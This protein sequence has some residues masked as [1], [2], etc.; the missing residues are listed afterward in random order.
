MKCTIL[1][2]MPLFLSMP[3][4]SE[5]RTTT[6][7]AKPTETT[8]PEKDSA[9]NIE[10]QFVDNQM[11]DISS[12]DE[13]SQLSAGE[14]PWI[15][16]LPR[17]GSNNMSTQGPPGEDSDDASFQ[18]AR[19]RMPSDASP[20]FE[21]EGVS[22]EN[23]S[24]SAGND[25]IPHSQSW[26]DWFFPP[27]NPNIQTTQSSPQFGRNGPADPSRKV[28]QTA[29]SVMGSSHQSA[30][31]Q[32]PMQQS[33]QRDDRPFPPRQ[34]NNSRNDRTQP[35]RRQ[36]AGRQS[37]VRY[38]LCPGC[39][40]NDDDTQCCIPCPAFQDQFQACYNVALACFCCPCHTKQMIDTGFETARDS[41][42]I[43]RDIAR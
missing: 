3:V 30:P 33:M 4:V 10:S 29:P 16:N 7:S 23:E 38:P 20:L 36:A 27:Q 9:R 37:G 15:A 25:P 13:D 19:E 35:Q 14:I 6:L 34:P 12:S 40:L 26:M 41:M 39:D 32:P 22:I 8:H 2:L 1:L 5:S 31:F 43:A 42:G 11:P 24:S 18:T 17:A 21:I 28:S